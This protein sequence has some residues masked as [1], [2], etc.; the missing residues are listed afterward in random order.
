MLPMI[1]ALYLGDR[2]DMRRGGKQ[3]RCIAARPECDSIV[4]IREAGGA[5]VAGYSDDWR[6]RMERRGMI[7]YPER[8]RRDEC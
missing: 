5:E 4:S 7:G 8:A 2:G 6:I 3:V 1:V